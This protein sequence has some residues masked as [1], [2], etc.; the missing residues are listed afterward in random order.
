MRTR[1]LVYLALAGVVC[2]GS[3]YAVAADAASRQRP[4]VV[5]TDRTPYTIH[6]FRFK[7][8]ERVTVTM[9]RTRVF[10]K[11]RVTA[12][13]SGAFVARFPR[14]RAHCHVFSI[15]AVGNRGTRVAIR[16][17][18]PRCTRLRP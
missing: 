18:P 8:G 16:E 7:R 14:L 15:S 13:R 4:V 17:M 1:W 10:A 2:A 3:W 5:V 9:R 6:G 11:K 12:G